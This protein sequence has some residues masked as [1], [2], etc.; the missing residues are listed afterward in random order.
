VL[1][2]GCLRPSP[3]ESGW[4]AFVRLILTFTAHPS[5][6]SR[7]DGVTE[8]FFNYPGGYSPGLCVGS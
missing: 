5:A 8:R 7:E 4:A 2:E 6:A 3:P 1:R